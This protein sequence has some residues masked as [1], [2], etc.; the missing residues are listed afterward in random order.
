MSGDFIMTDEEVQPIGELPHFHFTHFWSTGKAEDL[1]Q[2][3][4]TALDAHA[5][6]KNP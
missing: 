5:A 1:A 4:R 3:F 6:V 2:A